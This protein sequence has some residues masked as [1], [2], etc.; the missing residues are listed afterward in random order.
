MRNKREAY[1]FLVG[2]QGRKRSFGRPRCMM[3]MMMKKWIFM[4]YHG[5]A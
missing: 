1:R 4:K 2:K 5:R 3:M